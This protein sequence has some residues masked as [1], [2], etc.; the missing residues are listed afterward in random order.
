MKKD[1]FKFK[2]GERVFVLGKE[3]LCVVSGRGRMDFLSGGSLN[4][5]QI[6]GATCGDVAEY[7]LINHEEFKNIAR[8]ANEL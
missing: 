3:G 4:L 2:L 1:T 7:E 8:E 6:A 5:Y